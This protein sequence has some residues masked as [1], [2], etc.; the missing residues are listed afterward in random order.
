MNQK[1]F[2]DLICALRQD[3]PLTQSELAEKMGE[4]VS[5]VSQ[6]ERGVKK[7]LEPNLVMNLGT[8]LGLNTNERRQLILAASGLDE[9]HLTGKP[10]EVESLK[11]KKSMEILDKLMYL[12]G[13]LPFPGYIQDVFGESVAAN[14][15]AVKFYNITPEQM[16]IAGEI[17][18]GYTTIRMMFGDIISAV[19][20]TSYDKYLLNSIRSL[21]ELSLRYRAHPYFIYLMKE[22]RN[23]KKY[24]GFER[25]WR[26][27][28]I[29][30][31]DKDVEYDLFEFSHAFYGDMK[32][33]T[34]WQSVHTPHGE[35]IFVYNVPLDK[36]T[37]DVFDQLVA[38]EGR[39]AH[40]FAPWPEK[41]MI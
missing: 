37:S 24:P 6:I 34:P 12:L 35:L 8:A 17:P 26:H 15:A 36:H 19:V 33:A 3:V 11:L 18:G 1:D 40:R 13:Q 27:A 14:G 41:K 10:K 39:K 32:F 25:Y 29:A 20:T 2:G 5:V 9:F 21:R 31:D 30:E 38:G 7:Y 22:F 16:A 4:K 23:S 28:S